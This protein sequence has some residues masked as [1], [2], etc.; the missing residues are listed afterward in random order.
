MGNQFYQVET[1]LEAQDKE[2]LASEQYGVIQCVIDS[3]Q[4]TPNAQGKKIVRKGSIVG[5]N[6]SGKFQKATS[7][8]KASRVFGTGDAAFMVTAVNAGPEGNQ[9]TVEAVQQTGT[10]KELT[11]DVIGQDVVIDLGTDSAGDPAS[12]ANAIIAALNANP[13][14]SSLAVASLPDGSNGSGIVTAFPETPLQGGAP[15]GSGLTGDFFITAKEVDVTMGDATVTA[16]Y[17]ARVYEEALPDYPL[18]PSIKSRL[19]K[20][21]TFA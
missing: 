9:I 16:Y 13:Q 21:I 14:F 2:F 3:S 17:W 6:A 7:G 4:V 5:K 1:I 10:N 19:S 18:D 15:A 11:V 8:V 12:T 20:L